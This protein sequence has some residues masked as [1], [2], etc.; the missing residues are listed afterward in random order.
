[1]AKL[2]LVGFFG[3]GNYGDELFLRL[4]RRTLGQFHSVQPVNDLLHEPY[5]TES[6]QSVASRYDALVIGGGDLVIPNKISPLYWNSAWLTRPTYIAGIGVPTWIKD[7]RP[8]VIERMSQFFQHENVRYINARDD[9]SAEWIRSR[10]APRLPVRVHADLV[11]AMLFPPARR[12][13]RPTIGISLRHQRSGTTNLEYVE[14]AAASAQDAGFDVVRIVLATGNTAERDLAVAERMNITNSEIVCSD[15]LDV[16][17]AAIGGLHALV[18]M[19]FHGTVVATA[20][21]VPSVVLSATSKSR[22]L[23][24]RLDRLPLLSSMTDGSI[25]QKI[26]LAEIRVPDMVRRELCADADAGVRELV[27]MVAQDLR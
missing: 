27:N 5:F 4:W 19:K 10:L 26:G 2:G 3:W 25:F 21:G 1:M 7:E 23:Y 8:H 6:T 17:S 18:T 24:R 12:Y 22:F 16:L 15:D 11:F 14:R 9:E 20:Y 13:R